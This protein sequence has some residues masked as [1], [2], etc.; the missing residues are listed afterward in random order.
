MKINYAKTF[1]KDLDKIGG[2]QAVKDDILNIIN[3]LKES[4]SLS[5]IKNVRAIQGYPSYFRIRT[6]NYR[7]GLKRTEEGIDLIRCLHRKDIY[8]MFP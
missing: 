1:L 4:T 6:G 5:E 7:L 3:A 8:R 2:R